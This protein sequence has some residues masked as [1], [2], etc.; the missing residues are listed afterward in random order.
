[1]SSS[2]ICIALDYHRLK[3][4]GNKG[5]VVKC[6]VVFEVHWLKEW[7]GVYCVVVKIIVV[8]I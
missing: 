4:F 8:K 3:M 1:M 2:A 7:F 6:F 5:K